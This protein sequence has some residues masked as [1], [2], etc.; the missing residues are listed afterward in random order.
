M[1]YFKKLHVYYLYC[2]GLLLWRSH[3][4]ETR[5][6]QTQFMLT[7][8]YATARGRG[9][10]TSALPTCPPTVTILWMIFLHLYLPVTLKEL[11]ISHSALRTKSVSPVLDLHQLEFTVAVKKLIFKNCKPAIFLQVLVNAPGPCSSEA[12]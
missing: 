3:H 7:S 10:N 1:I 5:D 6:Y 4:T 11:Y 2:R 9:A 8:T 12:S